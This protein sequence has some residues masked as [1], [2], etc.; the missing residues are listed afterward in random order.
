MFRSGYGFHED[1]LKSKKTYF[2]EARMEAAHG[3]LGESCALLSNPKH[4]VPSLMETGARLY[5]DLGLADAYVNGDFSFVDKDEGLL[6]LNMILIA[7]S[8]SNPAVA[9]SNRESLRGWWTPML[10]T[11]GIASAKYFFQHIAR[12]DTLTQARR[13]ISCHYDLSN[14]LLE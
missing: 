2:N 3:I 10:F 4:M 6:N 9:K 7:N 11:A 8:D 1:G 12:E 14:E 13:N 5:A